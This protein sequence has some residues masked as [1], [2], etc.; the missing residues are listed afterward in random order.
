MRKVSGVQTFFGKRTLRQIYHILCIGWWRLHKVQVG[1]RLQD[2]AWNR[3]LHGSPMGTPSHQQPGHL[4]PLLLLFSPH[5]SFLFTSLALPYHP[6]LLFPELLFI[7]SCIFP[8]S[9]PHLPSWLDI[10]LVCALPVHCFVYRLIHQ[11]CSDQ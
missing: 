2:C 6:H 7:S 1:W 10:Y 5:I 4:S 3:T 8:I 9:P 11:Y